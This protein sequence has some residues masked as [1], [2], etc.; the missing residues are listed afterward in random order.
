M[1]FPFN[2]S[3]MYIVQVYS[4]LEEGEELSFKYYDSVNDK[5]IE[6]TEVLAFENLMN[7]GDGFNTFSLQSIMPEK[8]YLDTAY[9]N[10]FNPITTLGFSIP[11]ESE[12]RLSIYNL[13]GRE[14]ASLIDGNMQPGYHYVQWDAN[15]HSSGI[16]FV[17]MI[18]GEYINTQKLMLVK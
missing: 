12:V 7:V 18:A 15:N 14:V 11:I 8:F 16:Y 2:D 1:Y 3:Y 9:P 10:P 5:V 6:Y 4:N 13:Q 17:K